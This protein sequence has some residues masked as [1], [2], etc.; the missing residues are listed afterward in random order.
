MTE[1]IDIRLASKQTAFTEIPV[2]DISPLINGDNPL[3]VASQIGDA[4][5]KVG[6]FYI[7]NHRVSQ[8]LID[9]MYT[10][11]KRFFQASSRREEHT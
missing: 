7:K 2:I 4:C 1:F 11:T 3:R 10:L 8:Q 9:G 5:E 6:F